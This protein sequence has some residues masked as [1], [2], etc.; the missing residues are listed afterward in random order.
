MV[1]AERRETANQRMN[2]SGGYYRVYFAVCKMVFSLLTP[3]TLT[4]RPLLGN[5][6]L[7]II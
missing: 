4:E 3:L 2:S 5:S 1:A 7:Y 6:F